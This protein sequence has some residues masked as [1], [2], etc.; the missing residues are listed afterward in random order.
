MPTRRR[1]NR[2]LSS[3]ISWALAGLGHRLRRIA[4]SSRRAP[5]RPAGAR[6]KRAQEIAD[7]LSRLCTLPLERLVAIAPERAKGLMQSLGCTAFEARREKRFAWAAAVP[8][9]H[10]RRPFGICLSSKSAVHLAIVEGEPPADDGSMAREL[11][12]RVVERATIV[13]IAPA[14]ANAEGMPRPLNGVPQIVNHWAASLCSAA[15]AR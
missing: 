2:S 7:Y 14:D 4:T 12:A 3:S 5:V 6:V 13:E 8:V 1:Q 11:E 15:F 9:L 10:Q